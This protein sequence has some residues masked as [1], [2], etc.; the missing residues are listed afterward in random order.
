MN[1]HY[2]LSSAPAHERQ[3]YFNQLAKSYG[4]EVAGTQQDANVDPHVRALQDKVS[5]LESSLT[6]REQ[7]Q[8]NETKAKTAK[9]VEAFAAENPYFDEVADDIV[10]LLNGGATLKDAYEKAVWANP[11]TRAKELARVQTEAEKQFKENASKEVAAAKKATAANVRSRDT[12][13]AP[14]APKGTMEDTMR[15]TLRRIQDRAS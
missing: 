4:L 7:F 12:G 10:I 2:K 8:L 15:E 9:E 1:A 6:Q 14:T 3:S 11:M 13:K 5:Q